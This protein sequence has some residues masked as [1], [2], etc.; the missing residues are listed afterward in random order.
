MVYQTG[1]GTVDFSDRRRE[2]HMISNEGVN[3]CISGLRLF[4]RLPNPI[5]PPERN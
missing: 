1:G 3:R 2:D 4:E 5:H